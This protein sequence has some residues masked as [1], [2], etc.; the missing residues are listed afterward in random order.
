MN[1][2]IA[3]GGYLLVRISAREKRASLERARYER[4]CFCQRIKHFSAQENFYSVAEIAEISLWTLFDRLSTGFFRFDVSTYFV[5]TALYINFKN[6]QPT[7]L[8]TSRKNFQTV[9]MFVSE[10]RGKQQHRATKVSARQI[11]RVRKI[12]TKERNCGRRWFESDWKNR[13]LL[14]WLRPW[15]YS[16]RLCARVCTCEARFN[17]PREVADLLSRGPSESNFLAVPRDLSLHE[18]LLLDNLDGIFHS[19]SIPLCNTV[20]KCL[21]TLSDTDNRDKRETKMEKFERN[22]YR[23]VVKRVMQRSK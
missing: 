13:H 5:S 16:E 4:A 6:F 9:L 23:L 17:A 14:D 10:Y 11:T 7:R 8:D 19:T 20:C 12:E 18:F 22:V 1:D 3:A 2:A 15:A 21:D